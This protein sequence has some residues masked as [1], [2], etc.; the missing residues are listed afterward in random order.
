[1]RVLVVDDDKDNRESLRKLLQVWGH[2]VFLAHDGK[3][4]LDA[5][6][7]SKPQVVL[8]D[9][10]LGGMMNGW[11]VGERLREQGA[12]R[13]IALTGYGRDEDKARS[14]KAG[15]DAHITKPADLAVLKS[16]L[17]SL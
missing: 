11:E 6:A 12:I 15:F 1:M 13:L 5:V 16:L 3:S 10:A 8:L 9:I 4:A 7:S 17:E 14:N 2:E